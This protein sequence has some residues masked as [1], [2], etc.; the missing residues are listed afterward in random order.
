MRRLSTLA[1]VVDFVGMGRVDDH[2]AS[3]VH[4][5]RDSSLDSTGT[6]DSLSCAFLLADA[7]YVVVLYNFD[8]A[9]ELYVL[10]VAVRLDA[11]LIRR[12]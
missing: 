12:T 1:R 4:A 5:V 11:Y 7:A 9:Y 3:V 2:E 6:L 8:T 10:C